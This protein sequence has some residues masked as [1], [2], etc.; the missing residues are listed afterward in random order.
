MNTGLILCIPQ[1]EN[2]FLQHTGLQTV[3]LFLITTNKV[4]KYLTYNRLPKM[5]GGGKLQHRK[6]KVFQRRQGPV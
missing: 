5:C 3:A 6:R 2:L 1:E 4:K